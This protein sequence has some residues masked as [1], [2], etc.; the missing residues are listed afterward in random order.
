MMSCTAPTSA[1]HLLLHFSLY[2]HGGKPLITLDNKA[3]WISEVNITNWEYKTIWWWYIGLYSLFNL[4]KDFF[5]KDKDI[6]GHADV[7]VRLYHTNYYINYFSPFIIEAQST[8]I[9]YFCEFFMTW[10][11]I[12]LPP[13]SKAS[14]VVVVWVNKSSTK[15]HILEQMNLIQPHHIF[16]FKGGNLCLDPNTAP[17][18]GL[19]QTHTQ[20]TCTHSQAD[21]CKAV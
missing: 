2:F 6:I 3:Y 14:Q 5:Y 1:I 16:H 13:S 4:N 9:T 12:T 17:Y 7:S 20:S 8:C 18:M 19:I 21:I 11:I 15:L 10:L